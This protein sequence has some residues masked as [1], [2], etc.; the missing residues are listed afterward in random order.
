MVGIFC[1]SE[2][3][4]LY[5]VLFGGESIHNAIKL[6][7]LMT[8]PLMPKPSIVQKLIRHTPKSKVH[9][10]AILLAMEFKRIMEQKTTPID[11]Q[12]NNA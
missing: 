5:C 9:E 7:Q 4:L 3:T 12:L 2:W 1:C 6:Q 11:V 8:S 10:T